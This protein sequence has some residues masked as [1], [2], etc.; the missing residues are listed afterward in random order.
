MEEIQYIS[1]LLQCSFSHV[2]HVANVEAD[3]LAR[4]GVFV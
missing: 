1:R 2:L 4:E 3:A